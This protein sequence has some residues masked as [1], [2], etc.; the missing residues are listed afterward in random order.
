MLFTDQ[1]LVYRV[2]TSPNYLLTQK[3]FFH[4]KD[5]SNFTMVRNWPTLELLSLPVSAIY[6][7]DFFRGI[8]VQTFAVRGQ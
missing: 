5:K 4:M 7:V 6:P 8:S 3:K 2:E 1:M